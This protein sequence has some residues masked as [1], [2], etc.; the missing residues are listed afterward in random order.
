MNQFEI[1]LEVLKYVQGNMFEDGTVTDLGGYGDKAY[2]YI[3]L[4]NGDEL[5]VEITYKKSEVKE[6]EI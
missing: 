2:T 6:D 4:R 3:K 5:K 1:L